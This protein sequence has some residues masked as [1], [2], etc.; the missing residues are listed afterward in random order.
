M[1]EVEWEKMKWV[2]WHNNRRLFGPT[3]Y[4]TPAE[5]EEEFYANLNTLYKVD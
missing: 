4:I 1:R 2:D 5:A 3:G